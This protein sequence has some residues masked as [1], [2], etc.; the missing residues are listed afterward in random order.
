MKEEKKPLANVSFKR[1]YIETT[2]ICNLDCSFCPK[3][4]RTPAFMSVEAF[5]HI[6]EKIK[7]HTKHIYLHVMGEPLLHP[8]LS[9]LLKAAEDHGLTVQVTTNGTL[10]GK[11]GE[12]LCQ[13]KALRQVNVS[14]SSFEANELSV[15]LTDYLDDICAFIK[16]A[17]A[18]GVITSLRLWNLDSDVL[19]GENQLNEAILEYLEN[20]LQPGAEIVAHLRNHSSIK[21]LSRT[22]INLATRFS[23][24]DIQATQTEAVTFC[25]GLK[26]HIGIL[27]DGSVVPC[28]LDRSGEITLGNIFENNLTEIINSDR[29]KAM[30]F[31]FM[32]RVAVEPLCQKCGY[33]SRF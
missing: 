14:L 6:C 22:Y 11:R 16:V 5:N 8:D 21:L 24:P 26:D 3:T 15:Q 7:P 30:R 29:A 25:H 2:N 19:K 33:A 28:C 9:A 10:L 31:G 32:N 27:V 20:A 4:S 1:I 18:S 23:W 13:S 17:E 12:E